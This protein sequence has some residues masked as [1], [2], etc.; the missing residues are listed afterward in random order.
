MST[1]RHGKP[2]P[3]KGKPMAAE[4][5]DVKVGAKKLTPKVSLAP[6]PR[7]A[8]SKAPANP[9][10]T[11]KQ[12]EAELRDAL[13]AM[14]PRGKGSGAA[15]PESLEKR[16]LE[17]GEQDWGVQQEQYREPPAW[18]SIQVGAKGRVTLPAAIREH[19]GLAEGSF[20]VYRVTHYG[21]IELIPANLVPRDQ[22]YF[23]APEVQAGIAQSER[24][25]AEGTGDYITTHSWEETKAL[26]DSWKNEPGED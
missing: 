12:A 21:T 3:V 2:E 7:R 5:K 14:P 24:E 18:Y 15:T 17:P 22:L 10:I 23:Y 9:A 20:L 19:L 11:P 8:P 25:R 6:K 1:P 26:L 16:R 13:K 4:S